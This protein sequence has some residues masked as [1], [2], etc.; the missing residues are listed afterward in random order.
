MAEASSA[1][2]VNASAWPAARA[3]CIGTSNPP[4]SATLDAA[5]DSARAATATDAQRF[6]TAVIPDMVVSPC[7][8]AAGARSANVCVPRAH[9]QR[10]QRHRRSHRRELGV[11]LPVLTSWPTRLTG[12]VARLDSRERPRRMSYQQPSRT[13]VSRELP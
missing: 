11:T 1:C 7:P 12:A 9:I 4:A 5:A 6:V 13:E 10:D 8:H 3:F 2:A